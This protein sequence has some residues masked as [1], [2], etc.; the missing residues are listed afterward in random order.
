MS[1]AQKAAESGK[2]QSRMITMPNGVTY[3]VFTYKGKTYASPV[4]STGEIYPYDPNSKN[5]LGKRVANPTKMQTGGY[6][7]GPGTGTSDSIPAMLSN[8]E[9]VVRASAVQNVGIPTLDKINNMAKGG[10]VFVKG[11]NAYSTGGR[12]KFAEGTPGGL[13]SSNALY[14]I[15]VTL[16]GTDL[17]PEDVAKAIETQMRM[18]EAM[19]GR[20]RNF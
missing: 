10:P 9:Y 14:N 15:N 8:G 2:E 11:M 16:N 6:I 20:G 12:Y 7:S 19:N 4:G 17:S 13:G 1:D 18:R 3:T 5:P